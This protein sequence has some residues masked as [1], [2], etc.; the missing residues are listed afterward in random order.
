MSP[1]YYDLL[2]IEPGAD[3]DAIRSAYRDRLEGATQSE[4]AKLNKAWNVL[5]DPVQR[6]RYDGDAAGGTGPDDTADPDDDDTPV[7]ARTG[8]RPARG[9]GRPE[10]PAP[11]ERRPRP[12][13]RV[14]LEPTIGLPPGME[15]AETRARGTALLIDFLVLFVVYILAFAALL[16]A[17]VDQRYP[18]QTKRID[19]INKQTTQLDKQQTKADDR[20]G[21]SKLSKT[22]RATAKAESKSLGKQITKNNDK[23][24]TISKDF[25]GFA[26]V[27]YGVI[28]V[29]MLAIVVPPVALTGQTLGM[30]IRKV[31]VV[32]VDG[33]P[34]GWGGAFTRF[35]I[36]LALALFIPSLGAI[37]G[38]G[39]VVWFFRDRNR[40]GIH[41][42]LAKTLVVADNA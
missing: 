39:M 6:G 4:R 19:A 24:T 1:D 9:G 25:Q 8:A 18:A 27:L 37:A 22:D 33:S 10:R 16:P 35:L 42:K 17:L 3:K 21:N 15:F 2:G 23:V 38:L 20:A 30:R 29:V 32:R 28:L 13:A 36:P 40:Q 31:R 41:D 12:P 34:V 26:L 11:G 14:P 5:S 7:P